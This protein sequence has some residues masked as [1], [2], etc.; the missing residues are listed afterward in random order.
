MGLV[1]MFFIP[2]IKERAIEGM[3]CDVSL[4]RIDIFNSLLCDKP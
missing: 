1:I 2:T 4:A 3:L